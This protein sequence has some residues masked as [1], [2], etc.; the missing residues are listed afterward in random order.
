MMLVVLSHQLVSVI[1]LFIVALTLISFAKQGNLAGVRKLVLLVLPALVLFSVIVY[2]DV[3]TVLILWCFLIFQNKPQLVHGALRLYLIPEHGNNYPEFSCPQLFASCSVTYHCRKAVSGNLQLNAWILGIF[4][5]LLLELI[6]PYALFTV[7]PYRWILLLTY[8][9]AFFAV[10]G[11]L[12]I[13]LVSVKAGAVLF[14]LAVSFGFMLAPDNSAFPYYDRYPS[15][16]PSPMLQNSVPLCD[17]QDTANALQ[18]TKT[19]MPPNGRLLV[20]DAFT[21]WA[22]LHLNNSQMVQYGYNNPKIYA[23]QLVNNGSTICYYLIWWV[24]GWGGHGLANV[25]SSF[26]QVYRSGNI[27]IYCYNVSSNI[28]GGSGSNYSAHSMSEP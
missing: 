9:L 3:V 27:A 16:A 23:Q 21:G 2:A 19:N 17:C 12:K 4:I 15:Y 14:L 10:D 6:S 22:T 26:E 20:H 1:M 11:L 24:D 18:W 25:P 8:P 13:K 28:L 5:I 7:I